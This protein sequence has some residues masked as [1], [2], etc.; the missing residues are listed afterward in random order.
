MCGI[1]GAVWNDGGP[2]LDEAA[3]LAMADRIAHRGPDDSG[4]YRDGHAALGF[5]RL[6]IVDLAGGHQPLANEDG[7]IWTV[8]N[9][10][11]YNF[12]ALRRRLEARGHTLKTQG[13]TEVI[14]HLYE[15]EGPGF[16]ALLRGMFALAVWDAPRR[17]LVLAR[18]RMGQKPLIYR[19]DHDGNRL[20]FASELKALLALPADAF[21]RQVDR[22]AVD[23]YLT[24]GYVPQP[25]TILE[26]VNKLPPAHYAVWRD[27]RLS[28][29][30]Y[31]S[32]DWNAEQD[33]PPG[34]DV[35]RL[36]ALLAEAVAEQMIADVP[37]GAF[38]SGGVDS[39]IIVGLMQQ[40]SSRPV[41]TFAIGF[42]DPAFDET[43]YAEAAARYLGTEH[44]TFRIEPRAWETI[45]ALA[46][47]FDEPF[48]DSS[49][50]PTWFVARET[51]REVTVALTG[52]AGDELF[53]GYDRYRAVALAA[54]LD[55]LPEGVRAA[56]G[57]PLARAIPA[58][59][60][61][62]TPL[63]KVRRWLEA[64]AEKPV[65]RY[66]RWICL[67]DEPARAALYADGWLAALASADAPDPASILNRAFD[68]ASKRDPVTQATIAD[69]LTYLPGDL[70]VKVDLASMAHGL[71]CRSPFLDHRVVEMAAALPIRRKLRLRGGR[72]KVVLKQAFADL[73]PPA[74]RNRPKMGFGVPIDRW[75]RGPLRDELR[76]ILLDP[77]AL[78]R[79]LFRPESVARLIDE[80][81]T[82]R[83]DHAYKLWGLLMLELWFRH[84][85]DRSP[86]S[87]SPT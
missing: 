68:A 3:L 72:S 38:L 52:D 40:A 20:L 69:L 36:R 55:R 48:A 61:A 26:G 17:T 78:G 70:L 71:E 83:R 84:H 19:Y 41:K 7:S 87:E 82:S 2:P 81:I 35:E 16:V 51:R 39:T 4:T 34:E 23:Q 66:L 77:V 8:F 46:D 47:Q 14:V 50:L 62:K 86:S 59:A 73:L 28:L 49:A 10:E 44:H 57:G 1:V 32:P 65:G 80:H 43:R 30:R 5:R 12:P 22:A 6:S 64:V 25:A 21:P 33:S 45:A 11:I 37:L 13:D 42:D 24:Y 58:S 18:D 74:I 27:G 29:T 54:R 60:T 76:S 53:A 31:W 75:F 67:F 9:G 79:G 63:R 56:L 15:D 85:L